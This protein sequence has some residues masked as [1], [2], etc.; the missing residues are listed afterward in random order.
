MGAPIGQGIIVLLNLR[1]LVS[2]IGIVAINLFS[3][4]WER[5]WE[6]CGPEQSKSTPAT[7]EGESS[8]YQN[9]DEEGGNVLT[10][11]FSGKKLPAYNKF[12]LVGWVALALSHIFPRFSWVGVEFS[13]LNL[14]ALFLVAVIGYVQAVFVPQAIVERRFAAK[15]L[16][17]N[18]VSIVGS[19]LLGIMTYLQ[20]SVVPFYVAPSSGE[21]TSEK[22]DCRNKLALTSNSFSPIGISCP[23]IALEE[24]IGRRNV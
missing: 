2:L 5:K 19:L 14:S 16:L 12:A 3:W 23:T 21:Y 8:D 18:S 11:A 15:K 6:Q 10:S 17:W 4:Q 7:E 9:M 1:A 13:A 22:I 24:S 20:N